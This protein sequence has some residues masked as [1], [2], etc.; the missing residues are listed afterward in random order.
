M[1]LRNVSIPQQDYMVSQV[2]THNPKAYNPK[3]TGRF[4]TRMNMVVM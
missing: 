4:H 2:V 3:I 1:L